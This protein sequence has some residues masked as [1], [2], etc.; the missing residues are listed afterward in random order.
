MPAAPKA[1]AN[2]LGTYRDYIG[3][4]R[5]APMAFLSPRRII[6]WFRYYYFFLLFFP[7]LF[8]GASWVDVPSEGLEILG[9]R[10]S[11]DGDALLLLSKDKVCCCNL[12]EPDA[13]DDEEMSAEGGDREEEDRSGVSPTGQGEDEGGVVLRGRRQL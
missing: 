6:S 11:P 4:L 10:W 2:L 9:F 3:H 1:R 8:K 7:R 12:S 13:G 5:N